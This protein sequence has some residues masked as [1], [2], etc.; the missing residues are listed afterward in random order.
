[1]AA[2]SVGGPSCCVVAGDKDSLAVGLPP[3]AQAVFEAAGRL[4]TALDEHTKTLQAH[5]RSLL[6]EVEVATAER[7]NQ[8]L[9]RRDQRKEENFI[10]ETIAETAKPCLSN[11]IL[12]M[13]KFVL[14][15]NFQQ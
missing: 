2:P 12:K 4:T 11:R 1:M 8:N 10:A 3:S 7:Q 14:F 15:P 9:L 5:V 13:S 6:K